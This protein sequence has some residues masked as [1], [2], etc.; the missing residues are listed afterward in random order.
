MFF[1]LFRLLFF[2]S[3]WPIDTKTSLTSCNEF[4]ASKLIQNQSDEHS[5]S[6]CSLALFSQFYSNV[7]LFQTKLKKNFPAI[8]SIFLENFFLNL[9]WIFFR[10]NS[11][12]FSYL[13][14]GDK[15]I[16]AKSNIRLN[17]HSKIVMKMEIVPS[18]ERPVIF[19]QFYYSIFN[20]FIIK[21]RYC[22]QSI[23]R[24]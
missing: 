17:L 21:Y 7:V 14:D 6:C 23:H 9:N 2:I 3:S 22:C 5:N 16:N 20:I 18:N 12:L 19:N 24:N 11:N 10:Q 13:F 1:G 15:L 4:P 8:F